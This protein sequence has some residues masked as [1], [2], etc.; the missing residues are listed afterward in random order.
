[1]SCNEKVEGWKGIAGF[2]G[3]SVKKA[4]ALWKHHGLPLREYFGEFYALQEEL[5][6]YQKANDR[7]CPYQAKTSAPPPAM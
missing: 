1:M 6:A 5:E 3:V 4:R 2:L 7:P